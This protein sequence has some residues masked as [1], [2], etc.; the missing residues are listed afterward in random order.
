VE[1][2]EKI[3]H[4]ELCKATAKRF[5][6]G[7]ALYDYHCAS[8]IE[9]PDVFIMDGGHST[10]FE[11]KV[12]LSDFNADK[13]KDCRKKY[14]VPIW[15]KHI[16]NREA[17]EGKSKKTVLEFQKGDVEIT[18]IEKEHLGNSRY[19]VCPANVIPVEKLPEGWGLYWYKNG[20]FFLKKKSGK[21]R[22]N[23]KR[24]N[25]LAIH[26]LRRYASGDTT[27]IMINTYQYDPKGIKL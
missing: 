11:I 10:L 26:A 14:R 17:Y 19:F 18:L 24:E 23:L 22:A 21:F 27:G 1:Q 13:Y 8:I 9:H 2:P 12:S 15:A 7:L 16:E 4:S 20:R 3:T 6:K 25:I 5:T